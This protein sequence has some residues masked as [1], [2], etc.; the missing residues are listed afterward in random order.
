MHLKNPSLVLISG[1]F[2]F[3]SCIDGVDDA[4]S[5]DVASSSSVYATP[6]SSSSSLSVESSSS[7]VSVSSSSAVISGTGNL[8]SALSDGGKGRVMT[9]FDDGQDLSGYWYAY[10]DALDKGSSS[11]LWPS[12]V[13]ADIYGN[14]F[15]PLIS[16]YGG[17]RGT[18]VLKSTGAKPPFAGLGFNLVNEAQDGADITAWGGM[19]IV[20]TSTGSFALRLDEEGTVIGAEDVNYRAKLPAQSTPTV[21]D[22]AWS[23]FRT[24]WDGDLSESLNDA[25]KKMASIKFVF[26]GELS[27]TIGVD[28][29]FKIIA[30]GKYGGCS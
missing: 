29:D 24:L 7:A 5:V 21:R 26:R 28:I 2:L 15:G 18:A 1:I 17:I 4:K 30:I 9:G 11:F 6:F 3:I 25:L 20:Y 8:W 10:N 19:C 22:V 27:D 13:S 12:D 14:F 23:S 16:A